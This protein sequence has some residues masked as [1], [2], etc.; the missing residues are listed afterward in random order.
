MRMRRAVL[1]ASL[2]LE[3][4]SCRGL[5]VGEGRGMKICDKKMD[6]L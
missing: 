2:N 5:G 1:P 4:W 6:E 3:L